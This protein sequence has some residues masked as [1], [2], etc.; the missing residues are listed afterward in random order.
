[1]VR[2]AAALLTAPAL[3]LAY[4]AIAPGLPDLGDGDLAFVVADGLGLLFVAGVVAT[5]VPAWRAM[6]VLAIAGGGALVAALAMNLAGVGALANVPEALLGAA[7]GLVLAYLL[8]TP[9][10]A[11][12][13]PLFVAVVD[14]WSVASGPTAR[15]VQSAGD[16]V[17]LLSFDL[18]AW[19]GGSAGRLGLTDAVF[20]AMFCGW[21]WRFNLR[22]RA[23]LAGLGLGLL[24][25]LV[26]SLIFDE[27]IPALPLVAAGYLLPNLDRLIVQ[28]RRMRATPRDGAARPS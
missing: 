10:V 11:L 5:L 13:V 27:A 23:T 2:G 12:A 4:F 26:L 15:L 20:L 19:G 18:P 24:A 14:V 7:I 22:R 28:V 8:A 3:A 25:A 9:A 21:A 17:D 16:P 1:V 6:T